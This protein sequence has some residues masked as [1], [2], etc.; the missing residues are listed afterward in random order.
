MGTSRQG[1]RQRRREILG[2]VRVQNLEAEGVTGRAMFRPGKDDFAAMGNRNRRLGRLTAG[3]N[4]DGSV[5]IGVR[6]RCRPDRATAGD[7]IEAGG[8]DTANRIG[9]IVQMDPCALEIDIPVSANPRCDEPVHRRLLARCVVARIAG[10]V[11]PMACAQGYRRTISANGTEILRLDHIGVSFDPA[12]TITENARSRDCDFGKRSA[13]R[14]Q[15]GGR[16]G[17]CWHAHMVKERNGCLPVL[18]GNN[19]HF[20]AAT[21]SRIKQGLPSRGKP[22]SNNK[23]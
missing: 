6:A 15:N 23:R 21:V 18:V 22:G 4:L 10:H 11:E 5:I 7:P 12:R 17:C 16:T 3:G 20:R 9:S 2:P 14:C 19:T 13:A 1:C 8:T